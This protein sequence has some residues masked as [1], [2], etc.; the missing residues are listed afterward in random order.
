MTPA[1]RRTRVSH[2]GE[3]V[4]TPGRGATGSPSSLISH[5]VVMVM[6]SATA[7]RMHRINRRSSARMIGG[8]AKDR[9]TAKGYGYPGSPST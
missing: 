5:E 3:I 8:Q 4:A 7:A 2:P 1:A 9:G 6:P